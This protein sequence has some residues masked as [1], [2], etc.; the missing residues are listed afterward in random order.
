MCIRDRVYIGFDVN[1]LFNIS[2]SLLMSPPISMED[3]VETVVVRNITNGPGK[4]FY[5][6]ITE[7]LPN[8]LVLTVE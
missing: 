6:A 7:Q 1:K 5:D 8:A 3:G 2:S 4:M